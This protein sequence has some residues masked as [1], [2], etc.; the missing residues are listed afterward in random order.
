MT[1][2]ARPCTCYHHISAF[3][4]PCLLLG[5]SHLF[6]PRALM[7]CMPYSTTSPLV[8]VVE[9]SLALLRENV[10]AHKSSISTAHTASMDTCFQAT[11]NSRGC[12]PDPSSW[13][14]LSISSRTCF[15]RV[16]HSPNVR[17]VSSLIEHR[18]PTLHCLGHWKAIHV[19]ISRC[20][21]THVEPDTPPDATVQYHAALSGPHHSSTLTR[22]SS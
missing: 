6:F 5:S 4:L 13:A 21:N 18:P 22:L 9:H 7:P 10:S 8:Q 3:C 12:P 20:A 14:S 2:Y 15:E 19:S 16:K 1:R 17:H 11:D